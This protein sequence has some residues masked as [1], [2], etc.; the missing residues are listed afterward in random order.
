MGGN[1][2]A[3]VIGLGFTLFFILAVLTIALAVAGGIYMLASLLLNLLGTSFNSNAESV[4][5]Q[6]GGWSQGGKPVGNP[7]ASMPP[8][9]SKNPYAAPHSVK[10]VRGPAGSSLVPVPSFANAMVVVLLTALGAF[11]LWLGMVTVGGL[12]NSL[13]RNATVALLT[14]LLALALQLAGN[15]GLMS[16]IGSKFLPTTIGRSALVALLFYL[17]YFAIAFFF[18]FTMGFIGAILF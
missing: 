2:G 1:A 5:A 4:S 17:I 7:Y 13:V 6:A 3:A 10:S 14:G 15:V 12:L 18:S 16:L 9:A 11:V 8:N